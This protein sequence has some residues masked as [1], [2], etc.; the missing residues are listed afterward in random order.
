[1]RVGFVVVVTRIT[2]TFSE[3]SERTGVR[4]WTPILF[5]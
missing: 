1:M 3:F 2:V 5:F 4:G